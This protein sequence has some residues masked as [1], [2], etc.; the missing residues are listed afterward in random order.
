MLDDWRSG[1]FSW[2]AWDP[3]PGRC[4]DAVAGL[5]GVSP[6]TVSLHGSAAEGVATVARSLPPGSVVIPSGDYRSVLFPLLALDQER[7]PV[8]RADDAGPDGGAAADSI[9]R[10]IREDTVLVAVSQALTSAGL[11]LD[12][13]R[14]ATVAHAVGARLLVDMTQSFGVLD[15][16][17]AVLGIDHVIVHGYKWLL[18]PRG[19]AWM[20]TRAD[21][22]DRLSRLMRTGRAQP[23][24][25]GTSAGTWGF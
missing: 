8:L 1:R 13:A 9:A 12:L 10:V 4:R 19:T 18:C 17:L 2:R 11:R 23:S 21:R 14:L 20:A 3:V 24:R 25:T 7:N 15:W 5:A 6:A 22:L 16:N